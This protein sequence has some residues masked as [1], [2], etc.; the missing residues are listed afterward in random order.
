[1]QEEEEEEAIEGNRERNRSSQSE[2][3]E[4]REK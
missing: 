1:M 4:T 2:I 3:E